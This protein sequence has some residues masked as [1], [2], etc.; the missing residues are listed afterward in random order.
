MDPDFTACHRALHEHLGNAAIGNFSTQP[1]HA[2]VKHSHVFYG[3]CP[4]ALLEY[5]PECGLRKVLLRQPG[6]PRLDDLFGGQPRLLGVAAKPVNC[7]ED[8]APQAVNV[9]PRTPELARDLL[10]DHQP[11]RVV[12]ILV[13]L[14]LC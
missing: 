9:L 6:N 8:H 10:K 13:E 7:V 12:E 4:E 1:A 11:L 14:D 5:P 2:E 3:K